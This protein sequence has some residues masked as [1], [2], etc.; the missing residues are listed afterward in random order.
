MNAKELYDIWA[1]ADSVWSAWVSPVPFVEAQWVGPKTPTGDPV[2]TLDQ[3]DSLHQPP[4][5]SAWEAGIGDTA[6]IVNLPALESITT[7][8]ALAGRGFRPIPIFKA[9]G[10]EGAVIN[11]IP[12]ARA[13]VEGADGLP[14]INLSSDAPPAF[15][16]DSHRLSVFPAPGQFDNRWVVFPQDFPSGVF[17]RSKG[18]KQ[19]VLIQR[20]ESLERDLAEVLAFWK[21]A[22]LEIVAS[23]P[24]ASGQAAPFDVKPIG[25][26]SLARTAFVATMIA[27]FG[28]RRNSAGGFGSIVPDSSGGGG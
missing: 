22:G 25:R 18:I 28:L 1:P 27:S 8:L 9:S 21:R 12:T 3:P 6:L 20:P 23:V 11:T 13:L 16:I 15:L 4:D 14:R 26:W 2:P 7:G 10:G 5:I 17:L 24:T 19:V